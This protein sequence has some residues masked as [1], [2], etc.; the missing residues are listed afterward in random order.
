MTARR[1]DRV[2]LGW[3]YAALHAHPGPPPRRPV[4]P[5]QQRL[6]PGWVLAQQR[7]ERRLSLPLKA[8][9]AASAGLAA[10]TG[11]LGA[12]SV[13][14]PALTATGVVACLAGTVWCARDVWRGAR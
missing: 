7:E 6:D 2:Y 4:P 12:A 9:A 1:A 8:G 14:T 5:G 13:L 3:E 11:A 10:L